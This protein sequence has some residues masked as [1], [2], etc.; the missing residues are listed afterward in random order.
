MR[1][2][3][4]DAEPAFPRQRVVEIMRKAALAVTSQPIIIIEPRANRSD[5]LADSV[6]FMS[7]LEFHSVSFLKLFGSRRLAHFGLLSCAQCGNLPVRES[8]LA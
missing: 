6:L 5:S 8:G 2:R 7:K 3:R 4:A 1:L